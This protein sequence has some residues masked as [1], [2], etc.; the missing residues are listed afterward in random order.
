MP[1]SRLV[2]LVNNVYVGIFSFKIAMLLQMRLRK[3]VDELVGE[4]K[5][6]NIV[7]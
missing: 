7:W 5:V 2:V 1:W 4:T 3:F 6:L